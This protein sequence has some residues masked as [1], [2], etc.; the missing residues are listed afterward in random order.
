MII[1][2]LVYLKRNNQTLLL[3]RNKKEK[4]IN[5]GKWIGVGGKL[6]NGESPYE[7]AVRETY[8]ETGYRIHSARFVGMV[9][10]P[11]LY[12]GEDE[13]MFIY[14]SSHFS[15]EL[16]ET[17]EGELHWVND[18]EVGTLPTW[19]ADHHYLS[20]PNDDKAHEAKVVYQN[21]HLVSYE[22]H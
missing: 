7:C 9:S 12:Y 16:H 4:D 1:T 5:Q 3:Y 21:D 8:E 14:T 22:E 13:L 2:T 19:E 20:W 17:N 11:G 18:E 10:F 6:K 15:G